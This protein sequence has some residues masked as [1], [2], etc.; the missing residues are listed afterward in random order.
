MTDAP[1]EPPPERKPP[2]P[3][4]ERPRPARP[5]ELEVVEAEIAGREADIAELEKRLAGDWTDVDAIAAHR[6]ARDELTAL[7]ERWEALF[8]AAQT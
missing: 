7:L 4:P 5:T 6:R 1:A 3:R 2:K 8:E